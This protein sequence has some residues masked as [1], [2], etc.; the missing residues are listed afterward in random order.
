MKNLFSIILFSAISFFTFASAQDDVKR[1]IQLANEVKGDAAVEY[2]E[3]ALTKAE[4][5]SSDYEYILN[6]LGNYYMDANDNT[7]IN[8]ILGLMEEHN[9]NELKKEC[10]TLEC[11]LERAEYYKVSGKSDLAKDE[12]SLAFAMEL[13]NSQKAVLYERY[14]SFLSDQ[15]DFEPAGDHYAMSYETQVKASGISAEATNKMKMAGLCFYL[16]K[17]YDKAI[18]S[19]LIVIDN[20]D[21]YHFPNQWKATSLQGLGNAYSA[22][23]DYPNAII[24]Y[25]KWIEHLEKN[26]D[27]LEADYAKAYERL[28]AAEKFAGDYDASLT[29]YEKAIELYGNLGMFDEQENAKSG[30]KLC[31]LYANKEMK[32]DT[33]SN[34]EAE[35][36]RENKIRVILTSSINSLQQ[37]GEYLGSLYKVQTLATIAS[38]FA[39]LKEYNKAIEYYS[40]YLNKLRPVI[41]EEFLLKNPKERELIWQQELRNIME[42][43]SLIVEIPLENP[44][45]FAK[46]S[47]LIFEGQLLAKGILLSSNIEFDKILKR[48]GSAEMNSKYATIK[49]NLNKIDILKANH[50]SM[51]DI[52]AL[53]RTTDALQLELSRESAQLAHF[54]DYLKISLDDVVKSL[55]ADAA[56][57]EF[58]TLHSGLFP[59]QNLIIAIVVSK[60]FNK[61]IA[62]T[63]GSV[64]QIKEIISDQNKFSNNDYTFAIWGNIL[65]VTAGK[66]KIYFAPDGILNNLGIEYLTIDGVPL[67]QKLELVRV[68]S[69]KELCRQHNPISIQ[70]VALFGNIDYIE[71]DESSSINKT[72]GT[73]TLDGVSFSNLENTGREINGIYKVLKKMMKKNRIKTYTGSKASKEALL[74]LGASPI[75]LLHIATHGLY[76]DKKKISDNDAM[77]RSVLAMAGANLYDNFENNPGLVNASEIAEMALQDCELVVLSACDS[78][79]GK[80]GDDG[81]FGLQRG[82]KNAGAKTLL[83][84]LNGISDVVAADMMIKFYQYLFSDKNITK[85]EALQKVQEEIR[86]KYPNDNTWASFVLIDSFN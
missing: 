79:L 44:D 72:S 38:C 7:N 45:L 51:E 21:K 40:Q 76:L 9:Q 66:K 67:S 25:K 47:T 56:A 35:Q 22:K 37:S 39:Q 5:F 69:T 83:V 68:S 52:L 48:Y 81:V 6:Y 26:G 65:Q 15:R 54:T 73:R 3:K 46:L 82:F 24:S 20:V 11:H 80:L 42:M 28:A 64:G 31:L 8:R 19:H 29:N 60:E 43:N 16:G 14:A 13:N 86:V 27:A 41:A 70:N 57:I 18:E 34:A 10:N 58:V 12:F 1:L 49:Q 78:G 75:N 2:M 55:D 59:N 84:S 4:K 50:S 63:I 23:K 61:G 30:M 33:E 17:K 77:S 32:N 53:S 71:K 36:Q 62:V 85:H 74:S